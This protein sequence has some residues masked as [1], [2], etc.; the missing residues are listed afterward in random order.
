[1]FCL[2]G[3]LPAALLHTEQAV[4]S[5]QHKWEQIVQKPTSR[6][7]WPFLGT[8]SPEASPV[9]VLAAATE[10]AHSLN[11]HGTVLEALG[12][13]DES[14]AAWKRA[15]DLLSSGN[16]KGALGDST[17]HGQRNS[18]VGGLSSSC[19]RIFVLH[20]LSFVGNNNTGL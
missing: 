13:N 8:S 7:W 18:Q 16:V 17:N 14:Q 4:A 1:M 11:T 3:S 6:G 12:R 19:W 5:C 15:I 10:L 9:H 20:A 2:K